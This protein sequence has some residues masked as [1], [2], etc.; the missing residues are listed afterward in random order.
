MV[1]KRCNGSQWQSTMLNC[2][3]HK[4]AFLLFFFLTLF[5]WISSCA[6]R[7]GKESSWF[8]PS[9]YHSLF[10]VL[11]SCLLSKI[12]INKSVFS[13]SFPMRIAPSFWLL[14]WFFPKSIWSYSIP[15][16]SKGDLCSM[17]YSKRGYASDYNIY[18][19]DITP[20]PISCGIQHVR[21]YFWLLLHTE[22]RA[23]TTL[24]SI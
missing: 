1:F 5:H 18:V 14:S 20:W 19:F 12:K 4:K 23:L 8:L 16:F 3:L 21:L 22:Q 6:L 7:Q 17:Q 2:E 11:S 10:Y 13:V 9:L 24:E 15:F